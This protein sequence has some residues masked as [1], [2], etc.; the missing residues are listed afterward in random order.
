M[1]QTSICIGGLY[2]LNLGTKIQPLGTRTI[3]ISYQKGISSISHPKTRLLGDAIIDD[4][5]RANTEN[6]ENSSTDDAQSVTII[7]DEQGIVF[8]VDAGTIDLWLKDEG[9]DSKAFKTKAI[10]TVSSASKGAQAA[11]NAMAESGRDGVKLT[12]ESA[13]LV[14]K[15]GKTARTVPSRRCTTTEW[16]HH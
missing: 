3:I 16:T 15:Y 9:S 8:L 6:A 5:A 7:R 1:V 10:Q 11:G 4:D 14:A 13:E 2:H 12:K